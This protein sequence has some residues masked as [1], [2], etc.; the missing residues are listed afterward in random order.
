M[1]SACDFNHVLIT[2][3]FLPGYLEMRIR[4][5]APT[6]VQLLTVSCVRGAV[7]TWVCVMVRAPLPERVAPEKMLYIK[8]P[9]HCL[10]CIRRNIQLFIDMS[11][12]N[13][14]C[15]VSQ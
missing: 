14:S 4:Y 5:F 3:T 10:L 15:L 7:R 9:C 13:E 2:L 11:L 6:A 12:H 1:F 8:E